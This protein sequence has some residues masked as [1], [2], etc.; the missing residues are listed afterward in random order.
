MKKTVLVAI[1]LG[2]CTAVHADT[3]V[4]VYKITQTAN[5]WLVDVNASDMIIG[6]LK[7]SFKLKGT[8]IVDVNTDTLEPVTTYSAADTNDSPMLILQGK[9]V[10]GSTI[11]YRIIGLRP[12][13]NVTLKKMQ[14]SK[15]KKFFVRGQWD[16]DTEPNWASFV[17]LFGKA[18][19]TIIA[20]GSKNKVLVAKT[21][22]GTG[23][24]QNGDPNNPFNNERGPVT[25][26]ATLD[27]SITKKVNQGGNATTSTAVNYVVH[28]FPP[29]PDPLTWVIPPTESGVSGSRIQTMQCDDATSPSLPVEYKF[30]C[31]DNSSISSAWQTSTTYT[32]AVGSPHFYRWYAIA[33]DA[34]GNTTSKGNAVW[35]LQQ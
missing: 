15:G 3:A 33:R 32:V 11:N 17:S 18:S 7:K 30:V 29:Q 35:V 28:N 9:D 20:K 14:E 8:F 26:T 34:I 19:P 31:V 12:G 6:D 22:K 1:I 16:F 23:H 5:P 24:L 13:K 21:L 10:D 4:L 2:M 27:S 25:V